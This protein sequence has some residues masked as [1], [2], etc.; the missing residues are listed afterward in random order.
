MKIRPA[1]LYLMPNNP[2]CTQISLRLRRLARNI[3]RGRPYVRFIEAGSLVRNIDP[4]QKPDQAAEAY[5][6]L[7]DVHMRFR[8]PRQAYLAY[9]QGLRLTLPGTAQWAHLE[10]CRLQARLRLGVKVQLNKLEA[11]TTALSKNR[12]RKRGDREAL[13]RAQT[14]LARMKG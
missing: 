7:G 5:R 1:F 9:R 3:N 13:R 11:T 10:A 2:A 14:L 4:M 6:L 8:D 12:P